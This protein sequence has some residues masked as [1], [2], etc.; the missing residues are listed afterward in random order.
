[1]EP[2]PGWVLFVLVALGL[3]AAGAAW[4]A[5]KHARACGMLAVAF[6]LSSAILAIVDYAA[7]K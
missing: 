3:I 2:V 1:M 6:G 5:P 4:V 7:T